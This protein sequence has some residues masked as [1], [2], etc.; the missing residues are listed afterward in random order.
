MPETNK[1]T[2]TPGPWE[3]RYVPSGMPTDCVEFGTIGPDGL[4]TARVWRRED[5]SLIAAAPE[6]AGVAEALLLF[7][8]VDWDEEKRKRWT[9]LT[10][11]I[12]A[13]TKILCDFARDALKKAGAQ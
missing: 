3:A 4:E 6:L 1:G 11:E 2:F 7:H 5:V 10:G 13:T 8:S 9:E 12:E